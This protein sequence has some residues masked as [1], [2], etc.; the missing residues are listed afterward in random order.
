MSDILIGYLHTRTNP[1]KIKKLYAFNAVAKAEGVGFY[2]FTPRRV[3]IETQTIR[4][5][6]YENGQW[7]KKHFRFPDVIYNDSYPK[8]EW[9]AA[10]I[11]ELYKIIPYTSHSI[12]DK[13]TVYR[14]LL[15]GKK[16]AQHLISSRQVKGS[17]TVLT[18]LKEYGDVIMKPVCGR[19]GVGV[20]RIRPGSEGYAVSLR[21]EE[22]HFTQ[23]ELKD[24][25][26]SHITEEEYI[27][28]PFIECQTKF[29]APYDFRLHVQKDGS[30]CWGITAIYPRVAAGE[31]VIPNL[32]GG[33]YSAISNHF[34]EHE[35]GDDAV[36]MQDRLA[37]FGLRLA[38]HMDDIYDE[39]FDELGIDVGLDS[40]GYIWIFEVNW[41]PGPPPIWNVELDV[42]RNSI[43]YAAFLARR[44]KP[45]R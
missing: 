28:Q 3:N 36:L 19:Q 32:S 14:A 12:G 45:P 38:A 4:G 26:Q 2:Y 6:V 20:M 30:G 37:D 23:S 25:I 29:G 22:H 27:V 42:A 41:R 40:R 8:Y 15:K 5:L 7:T 13:L 10:V 1:D 21:E 24:F 44:G 33:G 17:N 18:S 16:F 35:F 43:L 9:G 31:G 11:E 39:A 34:F